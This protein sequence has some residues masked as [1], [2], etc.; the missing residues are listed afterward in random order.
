MHH[1]TVLRYRSIALKQLHMGA[2]KTITSEEES[3]WA[4]NGQGVDLKDKFDG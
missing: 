3:V 2:G 4:E 1:N